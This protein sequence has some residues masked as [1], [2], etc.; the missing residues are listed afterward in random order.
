MAQYKAWSCLNWTTWWKLDDATLDYARKALELDDEDHYVHSILGS[1][2]VAA[3]KTEQGRYHLIKAERLNPSDARNLAS[4]SIA[5]SLLGEAEK[6]IGMVELAVRLDPFHPDW[7]M[8]SLGMAYYVARDYERAIAALEVAPD[9]ICDSRAYL[10]AAHAQGGNLSAARRHVG[11]FIRT[12]CERLG[13][14]PKADIDN[15]VASIIGKSPFVRAEDTMHFR[16]GLR[17]AGLPVPIQDAS[18]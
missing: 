17:L 7:Y 11:E 14:D 6:A 12:S 8:T 13:G 15:Y 1:V 18:N 3:G 4:S 2:L 9:G 5:F 10:A 16:E